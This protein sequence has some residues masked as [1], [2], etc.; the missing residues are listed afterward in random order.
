MKKK[1]GVEKNT[2]SALTKIRKDHH[3]RNKKRLIT[4]VFRF[5]TLFMDLNPGTLKQ[6][7]AKE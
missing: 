7:E 2:L 5:S 6:F 4:L 1:I 3:E